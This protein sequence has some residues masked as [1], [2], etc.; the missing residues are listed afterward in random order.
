MTNRLLVLALLALTAATAVADDAKK[1][2]LFPE[3]KFETSEGDFVV[4]LDGRRAPLTTRN[5]VGYVRDGHYTGTVFHRVIP[6]FMAQGGGFDKDLTEKPTRDPIANES[7]N[8][9]SNLRGTIAM[10]RTGDPHSG[11]AQ[12]YIN[13]VDNQRLD[14]SPRRWGYAVFGTVTEGME[15]LDKI[16]AIPTG[17]KGQFRSDVPETAVIIKQATVTNE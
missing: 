5:F 3:V 11:K 15:T 2:P 16:A 10:A 14:P 6:G 17:G 8:G 1:I 12:F 9:L 13:L 7:G 4:R